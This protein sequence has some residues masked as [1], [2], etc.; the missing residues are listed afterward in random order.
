ME[1]VEVLVRRMQAG[2]MDAFDQIFGLY[3]S[4]LLRT[5][6]LISGNHADSED[7]V[8]ET[9]VKCYCN[10]GK[11]KNPAVFSTW[12]YQILTRTAWR[13]GKKRGKEMPVEQFFDEDLG[14][15]QEDSPLEQMLRR[16]IRE[17]LYQSILKLDQKQR[18]VVILYYFNELSTREISQV[19]GCFEGTVKSRLYAAR[20]ALEK[21]LNGRRPDATGSGRYLNEDSGRERSRLRGTGNV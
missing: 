17:E 18:T 9:F 6:W 7:I 10:C 21:S 3:Q 4:R 12:L 20:K 1:E 11:L 8:Q 14:Q 5:A 15:G 16:E 19:V 2:D 13:Y